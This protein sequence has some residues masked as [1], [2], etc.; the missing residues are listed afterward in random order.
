VIVSCGTGRDDGVLGD[1]AAC[2][3]SMGVAWA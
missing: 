2:M 3:R 1:D